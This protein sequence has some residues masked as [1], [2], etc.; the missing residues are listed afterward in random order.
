VDD[1][2][3]K[4]GVYIFPP[5]VSWHA[6]PISNDSYQDVKTHATGVMSM[7]QP[8]AIAC[9]VLAILAGCAD[10]SSDTREQSPKRG[11]ATAEDLGG[12]SD[13]RALGKPRPSAL[14]A[15][16]AGTWVFDFDKTTDAH[17]AAGASKEE[18]ERLRKMYA[19]DPRLGRLHADLVITGNQAV[20]SG[21]PSEEYDFFAIHQHGNKVCGK[22]WHHEDRNDPGDMTKCY[23]RM[24]KVENRLQLEV[25]MSG[26]SSDLSDPDIAALLA[27]NPS[28]PPVDLDT[29]AKCDA[30]KP[31]SGQWT[32]WLIYVFTRSR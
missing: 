30:D 2:V 7:P 29:S 31:A 1:L 21:I 13:T 32:P 11:V 3:E 14:L 6:L 17:Q 4:L 26:G 22:A 12:L 19:Q 9:L 25:R 16:F 8:R 24:A 23:V 28:P 27:Q 15:P 10:N 5:L 18:I 20:G